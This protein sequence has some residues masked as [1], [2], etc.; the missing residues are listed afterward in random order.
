[1]SEQ[2]IATSKVA[3]TWAWF[4]QRLSAVLLVVFLGIHLYVAHFMDVGAETGE[5]PLITFNEVSVRLDQLIY[6]VVD[7]GMLSMVLLHGLN[8]LRTVLFDFDMFAKRK[9]LM[10]VTLW[11]VG[12]A[13]LVWGILILFPFVTGG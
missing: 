6:I 8:G 11:V 2:R 10:D 13:T 12:I 3:G 4:F 7:Y 1:M 9:K 5:E